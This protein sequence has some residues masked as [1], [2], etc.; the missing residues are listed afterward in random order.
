M[1]KEKRRPV[2]G[3]ELGRPFSPP[4][5]KEDRS[6]PRITKTLTPGKADP[7]LDITN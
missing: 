7:S 1:R 3:Y 2:R 6:D 5:E 4:P